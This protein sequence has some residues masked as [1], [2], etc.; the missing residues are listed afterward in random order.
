M[1]RYIGVTTALWWWSNWTGGT[2]LHVHSSRHEPPGVSD[3]D[4][5]L[6]RTRAIASIRDP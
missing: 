3:V 1:R 5:G 4:A 6:L 2:V